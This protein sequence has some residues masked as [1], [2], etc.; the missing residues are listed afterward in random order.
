[1]TLITN[2]V[3]VLEALSYLTVIVGFPIAIYQYR[4]NARKEQNDREY[5]TYNALDEKYIEFLRLCY[6]SPELDV[7]DIPDQNP[8]PLNEGEKKKELVAYTMLFSI[9]ERAFL[10]YHDQSDVL[11]QRQ[12][13]GWLQFIQHYCSRENFRR[14]WTASGATFDTQFQHFMSTEMQCLTISPQQIQPPHGKS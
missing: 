3:T 10:M 7:F 8:K 11:R 5:G 9:F 4:R 6:D 1:M 14:A 12:W 2:A 13:S